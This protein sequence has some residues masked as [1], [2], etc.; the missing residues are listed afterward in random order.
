MRNLDILQY[1]PKKRVLITAREKE[2][3]KLIALGY[4]DPEIGSRLFLSKFTI[5]THRK[6]LIR[7]F[8]AKNA[9]NLILKAM[10]ENSMQL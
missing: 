7:K 6:S 5:N 2:V 4:T 9:C 3:L 1:T 10:Q 8:D